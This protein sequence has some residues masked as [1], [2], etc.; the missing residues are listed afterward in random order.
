M[1]LVQ[2]YNTKVMENNYID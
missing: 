1:Q 2:E